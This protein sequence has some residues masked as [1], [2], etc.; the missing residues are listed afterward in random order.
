MSSKFILQDPG[1]GLYI[2]CRSTGITPWTLT[3][4]LEE[5][6]DF[7]SIDSAMDYCKRLNSLV[8]LNVLEVNIEIKQLKPITRLEIVLARNTHLDS[9]HIG[10]K[11]NGYLYFHDVLTDDCYCWENDEWELCDTK[12][13]KGFRSIT[14]REENV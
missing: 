4:G 12:G 10:G 8:T 11:G 6:M 2:S 9:T 1:T 13:V 3:K 7:S 5:A 14:I